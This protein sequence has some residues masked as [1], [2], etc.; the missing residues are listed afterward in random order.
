MKLS[1]RHKKRTQRGSPKPTK[2]NGKLEP[3]SVQSQT[4]VG[5]QQGSNDDAVCGDSDVNRLIGE[6]WEAEVDF[7]GVSVPCL[8]DGGSM[9]ATVTELLL[10]IILHMTDKGL[11]DCGWLGLKSANGLKIP[12]LGY[13]DLDVNILGVLLPHRGVLIVKDSSDY[14]MRQKKA[15]VPGVLGMNIFNPLY[16]E[17]LKRYGPDLWEA[18]VFQSAPPGLRR[19]LRYCEVME[20]MASSPDPH[21]VRVQGKNSLC[22]PAGSLKY[23]YPVPCY[24]PTCTLKPACVT[25]LN[26]SRER[27][28]VCSSY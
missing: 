25:L 11:R 12:Y 18:P 7:A 10:T 8:L 27:Q 20:A 15:A 5:Q 4:L 28:G 26:E 23:R 24:L 14:Y 9:V 13:V 21:L 22:I 16:C 17:L 19:I 3:A 1:C 2:A 6:C